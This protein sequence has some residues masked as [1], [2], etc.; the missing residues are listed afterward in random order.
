MEGDRGPGEL[1]RYLLGQVVGWAVA[2]LLLAWLVRGVGLP[3]WLWLVLAVFVVK[4]LALLPAMRRAWGP[5]RTGPATL[6]GAR[7]S[8]V[9]PLAPSG[10]VRVGAELWAAELAHPETTVPAGQPVIVRARRGIVLVVDPLP[11]APTG[12]G[13]H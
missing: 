1:T 4:D 7:G 6:I 3:G 12:A 10:Q 5:P 9:E 8:A 2:A 11:P 13:A